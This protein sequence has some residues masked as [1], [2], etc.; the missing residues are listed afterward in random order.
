MDGFVIRSGNTNRV[1]ALAIAV[2]AVVFALLA[3]AS[4]RPATASGAD[5]Q[6]RTRVIVTL[7][8]VEADASAETI[9][10]AADALLAILPVDD[11][12][13]VNR[14]NVLPYLTLSAGPSALSVLQSSGLVAHLERDGAVSAAS[15]KGKSKP[16][17]RKCKKL[18]LGDGSVVRV[19]KRK[20]AA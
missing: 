12:T 9:A 13:L 1:R 19:C 8:V 4:I 14:P 2:T 11:Y 20:K 18:K 7:A 15:G 6:D 3:F 10:L 17:K 5:G 16:K